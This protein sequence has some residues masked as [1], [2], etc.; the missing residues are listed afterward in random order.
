M[1]KLPADFVYEKYGYKFRFV[2]EQDAEFILSLRTDDK[3][4]QFIHATDKSLPKQIEWIREY[5]KREKKGGDYYFVMYKAETPIG[6]VRIYNI[7]DKTFTAGSWVMKHGLSAEDIV[8]STLMVRE[9]AFEILDFELED[10][11]DG[12]HVDNKKVMKYNLGW[13]MKPYKH[14]QDVTGEFVALSLTKE[15]YLKVKPKKMRILGY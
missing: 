15:D 14:F 5:K 9:I 4:S 3:L 7:H 6:L 8:A 12:V 2:N 10:D 1:N 13:G 11:F